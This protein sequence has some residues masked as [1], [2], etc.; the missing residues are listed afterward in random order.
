MKDKYFN[1]YYN[2]DAGQG[3]FNAVAEDLFSMR[4]TILFLIMLMLSASFVKGQ[5]PI[6]SPAEVYIVP[7]TPVL[8][9]RL[10]IIK[11]LGRHM[12]RQLFEAPK[13]HAYVFSISLA[14]DAAGKVDTIYFSDH[15]SKALEGIIERGPG[16]LNDL[17][18][19]AFKGKFNNKILLLPIVIKRYDAEQIDNSVDFLNELSAIWPKFM[20]TDNT[21]TL[22]LL[23]PFI[24]YYY[25]AIRKVEVP[26]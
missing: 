20:N 17:K 21:K 15:M 16:L 7:S 14:F 18:A 8:D 10:P 23:E 26:D 1:L 13:N 11:V 4:K 24:N 12:K 2:H 6:S 9:H 5:T 19:I 25:P 22:V 3:Y